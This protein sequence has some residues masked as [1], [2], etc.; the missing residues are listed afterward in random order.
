MTPRLTI[1]LPLKGRYLFTLRFLWHAN[2]AGLP[3][4]F[5]I[6]DG[7]V[8]PA[9]AE[10]LE[11]SAELFP[12]L[13][14][15]YVR[16]PDDRN[17]SCFFAKMADALSRVT[18]PYA[19]LADNDDFLAFGGI[20]RA[21]DFLQSNADYICCGG[22]VAGFSVYSG[23][24]NPSR[25]L[26]G[27]LNRLYNYYSS[28]D[29]A[30]PIV[31]ERL[32][33]GALKHWIYYAVVRTDALAT[34]CREIAELDFSDLLIHEVFHVMRV[35]TQGKARSDSATIGYLRQY[36][37]S[38]YS[39]FKKDWVHHLVRS[40]FTSDI[41]ALVERIS[42]LA[43]AADGTDAAVVAE[44]VRVVLEDKF[45]QFHWASYGSLQEI[46]QTLRSKAPSLV[47]WLQNRPRYTVGRERSA[48]LRQLAN[49][50]ASQEYVTRFRAE[51]AAIEEVISG[52]AFANFV[53]PLLPVLGPAAEL[54]DDRSL[55]RRLAT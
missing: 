50:G 6:A 19:M 43:A 36:G 17:F 53:R 21:V 3:Y 45:R 39:S 5:L 32:R 28:A 42:V 20:E 37:T 51:L 4:R 55:P 26:R 30:S 23:L 31:V 24:N 15:Q 54:R 47:T 25:G 2:K 16:Y 10:L 35:L 22:R 33:Q 7:Q 44:D 38:L 29:V 9:L 8:H 40:R 13:D 46:K 52:D 27:K 18:T 12:N 41:H 48:L 1:V 14:L 34:V 49:A 11:N